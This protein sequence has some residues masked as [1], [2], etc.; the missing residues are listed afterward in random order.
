MSTRSPADSWHGHPFRTRVGALAL[1]GMVGLTTAGCLTRPPH[2]PGPPSQQVAFTEPGVHTW[3]V[4]RGVHYAT[5]EVT[6]A[7]GGPGRDADADGGAGAVATATIPVEHGSTLT[8]VVGGRG[9]APAD[10]DEA[11]V[12]GQPVPGGDGGTGGGAAGGAGAAHLSAPQYAIFFDGG[13]GGGGGGGASDVR[14]G[15]GDE[16]GLAS[17]LVVAGGGG[18]GGAVPGGDAGLVGSAGADGLHE[19][20]T[21]PQPPQPDVP[22]PGG[23]GGTA[24][25]G[26]AGSG[27]GLAGVLGA[28]GRGADAPPVS[29]DG[30]G[31]SPA[32][33][34]LGHGGGGGGGGAFGGGGGDSGHSLSV[35]GTSVRRTASG[36]G[37]GASYITPDAVCVSPVTVATE[38]ADGAVTITFH[39]GARP[40]TCP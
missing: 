3:E 23:S 33:T 38:V 2:A 7:G 26:G 12:P 5:V 4:P 40:P 30:T 16:T 18:G 32:L 6:G 35:G 9:G 39:R 13:P 36:G 22:V 25:A 29:I 19:W 37:G 31:G 11:T 1:A 28:G 24:T 17:R 27:R 8:I 20:L 15:A 10:P 21:Q 34:Y 14:M